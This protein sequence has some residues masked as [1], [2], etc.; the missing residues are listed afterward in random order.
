MEENFVRY[1]PLFYVNPSHNYSLLERQIFP[2]C[3]IGNT[4][5]TDT[6]LYFNFY[7]EKME[8]IRLERFLGNIDVARLTYDQIQTPPPLHKPPRPTPSPPPSLSSPIGA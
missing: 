6:R 1:N 4:I 3:L 8:S 5:I 7:L 2:N